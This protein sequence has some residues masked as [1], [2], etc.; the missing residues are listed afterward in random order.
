M[1]IVA[2]HGNP[3]NDG[4]TD[5]KALRTAS[6]SLGLGDADIEFI[7]DGHKL[8]ITAIAASTLKLKGRNGMATI[9]PPSQNDYFVNL[10]DKFL[11]F[12][13][14]ILNDFVGMETEGSGRNTTFT[15]CIVKSPFPTL[16]TQIAERNTTGNSRIGILIDCHF[17]NQNT[18]FDLG[19]IKNSTISGDAGAVFYVKR[20]VD[21]LSEVLDSI[22]TAP[23]LKTL[24]Q[25]QIR[26]VL[27][28]STTTFTYDDGNG[29][30]VNQDN[31]ATFQTA[32]TTHG[33]GFDL[34]GCQTAD[35]A[36][37]YIDY[38]KENYLMKQTC[39]GVDMSSDFGVVGYY[40]VGKALNATDA[41][42]ANN[43]NYTLVGDA[44]ET[45]GAADITQTSQDLTG[46]G[47]AVIE[48]IR[49]EFDN[50]LANGRAFSSGGNLGVAVVDGTDLTALGV[51]LVDGDVY[52]FEGFTE[53]RTS[54]RAIALPGS[55]SIVALAG[56]TVNEAD[57]T[58]SIRP[59]IDYS[60]KLK[61]PF[62]LWK[63]GKTEP[64]TY[65]YAY[66]NEDL[67][68]DSSGRTNAEAG[69]DEASRKR[70]TGR[71]LITMPT[72]NI[73]QIPS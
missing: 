58:G 34:T 53:V 66:W 27:F 1:K 42:W 60:G 36:D 28:A 21:S 72:V 68:I 4:T 17:H 37:I 23:E 16:S 44:Y 67:W 8:S 50:G 18:E 64:L 54:L 57:G 39:I 46:G 7:G 69:Y 5:K 19:S 38:S 47:N 11:F 49:G 26:N 45:T 31:F 25:F 20:K 56:E 15:N 13:D 22:F 3:S 55:E 51:N 12:E 32:N 71:W 62:K 52:W 14:L 59:V 10:R 73:D 9:S 41:G 35:I 24:V 48:A 6:D 70:M 65:S 33:W 61:V 30:S 40:K 43:N 2:L 63:D 29:N